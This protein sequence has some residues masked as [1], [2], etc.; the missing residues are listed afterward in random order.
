MS[1]CLVT[2]ASGFVGSNLVAH[3]HRLGW[4]VRCLVR[5]QSKTEYLESLGVELTQ[6]H[7]SDPESLRRAVEGVQVVFH[8]AGR[9]HALNR[10]QLDR[11]NVAGTRHVAQ[12]CAAQSQPPV[13]VLIS[14]L[15]AGGPAMSEAPRCETDLDQPISHYG[16]SKLLA[17]DAAVELADNVPLAIVRPPIIFGPADRAGLALFQTVWRT[18]LHPLPGRRQLPLSVIHVADLCDALVRVA[19]HGSRV[20]GADHSVASRSAGTYYVAAERTISFKEMGQMAADSLGCRAIVLPVPKALFWMAGGAFELLGQI[21][22]RPAKLGLDKIR[23][24]TA[25]GW[26]CSDEKIRQEL[27]YRPDAPLQQRFDETAQWY[28][29]H[30]WL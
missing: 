18:R 28:R 26:V 13:L 7:L 16:T 1:R 11:D 5:Q 3:L 20:S 14:S 8:I 25:P 23:E 4:E 24:A 21:R 19:E 30:G 27:G 10:R 29:A 22:R 12:A 6:G 17:E 9:V 15:A 2:G